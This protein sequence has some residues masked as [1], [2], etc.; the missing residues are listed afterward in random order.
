MKLLKN[1]MT[2]IAIAVSLAACSEN[3]NNDEKTVTDSTNPVAEKVVKH[4]S[5]DK[6]FQQL[7][8]HVPADTAYLVTNKKALSEDALSFHLKR[9]QQALSMWLDLLK[10]TDADVQTTSSST[11]ADNEPNTQDSETNASA[12]DFFIALL[13]DLQANMSVD[14]VANIGLKVDGHSALYG[15]D[16]APIIRYE[17]VDKAAVKATIT[18]AEK[19]SGYGV[20]WKKCGDYDCVELSDTTS[21]NDADSDKKGGVIIVLLEDQI[22]VGLFSA[23]N[24]KTVMDHLT[25]QSKPQSSYTV[26][27]WNTFLTENKYPGYGDGYVDLKKVSKTLESFML[28]AQ[29]DNAIKTDETFDETSFKAC[30]ALA[31][32][33]LDHVPEA[34]FGIKAITDDTMAYEIVL[35]TS[36]TVSAA[37]GAI[38]NALE[39]MQQAVNPVIDFGLNLNFGK[40]R[41]GLTQYT[42]FLIETAEAVHCDAVKPAE[43]RKAMG[44][45]AMATMMGVGQFKAIYVAVNDVKMDANSKPEKIDFY[46][47]VLADNPGIL[48]QMLGMV[49]PAFATISL[50]K[51]GTAVKLPEELIPPNPTGVSPEVYVSQK[52]KL[53]NIMVGDIKPALKPFKTENPAFF[54]NTVDSKRYY[55]MIGDV[56]SVSPTGDEDEDAKKAMKMMTQM[57][58]FTGKVHTEIGAD[59]RGIVINYSVEYD[60]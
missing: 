48:L 17:I 38:P 30:Y 24:K 51:D 15:V 33:H 49:N 14:K 11:D 19:S 57:G 44:G 39:G 54:W 2:A 10:E 58:E 40:L 3:H 52:G 46:A 47:S 21:G 42:Q 31:N 27:N 34:T 32:K 20:E 8:S 13:E 35:K 36:P 23:D 16:L 37:I 43:V 60:Q 12:G 7:L 26:A 22:A 45:F 56:M 18:R 55:Q 25:G 28:E 1:S 6:S 41:D 4:T 9:S 53:L 5:A 50:P 29:K 59:A